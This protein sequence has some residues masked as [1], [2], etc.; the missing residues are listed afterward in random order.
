MCGRAAADPAEKLPKNARER[1]R[2][3]YDRPFMAQHYQPQ[4]VLTAARM[5]T[6]RGWMSATLRLTPEQP[7]IDFLE[8]AHLFITMT[9]VQ[10]DA[11]EQKIEY[12]SFQRAAIGLMLAP[13]GTSHKQRVGDPTFKQTRVLCLFEQ[14]AVRGVLE[15]P[16][17]VRVS[18][19]FMNREGFVQ[20]TG[21]HVRLPNAEGE[22]T[23]EA[24]S[25]ALVNTAHI[26][27]VSEIIKK[28]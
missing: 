28:S 6:R 5:Y 21:A 4:Q 1:L 13:P 24:H 19:Y 9:S 14:G 22:R 26:M 8:R 20:L 11:Y 12:L 18:D 27:G 16:P 23:N 15:I 3:G 2:A 10:F 17:R 25:I 7:M